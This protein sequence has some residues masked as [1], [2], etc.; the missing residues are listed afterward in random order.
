MNYSELFAPIQVNQMILKNRIIAAPIVSHVSKEK[1][2]SGISM[3]IIGCGFIKEKHA[4]IK[5]DV[6]MFD[7][8]YREETRAKLDFYRQGGAKVSLELMHAGMYART[9]KN[10]DYVYGPCDLV[11]DDSMVVKAMNETDMEKVAESFALSALDAKKMGFDMV[12]L[13]FAHGWLASQFLSLHWNHRTDEFGGSMENRVKFPLMILKKVREAVGR[14]FPIDIRM[15]GEDHLDRGTTIDEAVYFAKVASQ[16]VDMLHV[17]FGTD[18]NR[19]GNIKMA[20]TTLEQHH[21]NIHLSKEIKKNVN[22]PVVVVGSIETPEEAQMIIKE[23]YADCVALGRALVA[24]PLWAKK[25]Y[26]DRE[27]DIVPCLR[28]LNCF[29]I[30]TDRWNVG[31]SV[32][33]RY[34]KEDQ[35]P[36]VLE[37]AKTLKKVF[38]IGGG[39]AGMKAALTC[40]QRGHDVTLFEK[41]ELGGLISFSD[42]ATSKKDLKRYKDYLIDQIHQSPVHL[43]I[44]KS[45]TPSDIKERKPDALMIAIGAKMIIPNIKGI[46]AEHVLPVTEAYTKMNQLSDEVVI[47]GGGTS[48]IEMALELCALNKQVTVIEMGDKI[49]QSANMLYKVA[50]QKKMQKFPSLNI[51]LNTR[52]V[53]ITHEGVHIEYKNEKRFLKCKHVI[54]GFKPNDE[55]NAFYGITPETYVIG[56]CQRV[57]TVMEANK[58]AY[59]N[60]LII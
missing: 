29:H 38:V 19:E 46:E 42:Y 56:D 10:V 50:L 58:D 53:E 25:V 49:N 39:P 34:N 17:S 5:G 55:A 1:V 3:A 31:C 36:L 11:R 48:G 8:Y 43:E 7:K 23:G 59:F 26:E 6:Y 13:H 16:Y 21:L 22:I 4:P 40:A 24:D 37:Q 35:Y 20:A 15:N 30:A 33:A 57:A 12:T 45:V 54:L 51:L 47:L 52:C 14:D 9:D 27:K 32:N 60:S 2:T 41:H 44:G 28:C 18:I